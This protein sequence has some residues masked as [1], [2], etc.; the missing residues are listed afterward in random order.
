MDEINEKIVELIRLAEKKQDKPT[1]IILLTLQA[2][3]ITGDDEFFAEKV[4]ELVI[5]DLFPREI[6]RMKAQ[7]N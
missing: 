2:T 7:K 5:S 4:N 1:Q 3:R 6:E